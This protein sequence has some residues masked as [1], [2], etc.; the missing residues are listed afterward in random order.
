[1]Y[2]YIYIH[3]FIYHRRCIT[4]AVDTAQLIKTL[5]SLGLHYTVAEVTALHDQGIS[6]GVYNEVTNCDM[7]YELLILVTPL[8][9]RF[10]NY[11]CR[12]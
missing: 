11:I 3:T 8:F 1:M 2:T 12:F 9:R 10:L 6:V 7:R 5:L 4:I